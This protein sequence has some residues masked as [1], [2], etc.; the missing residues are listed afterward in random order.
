MSMEKQRIQPIE[1]FSLSDRIEQRITEYIK[2]NNLKPGDA[3][4]KEI[5]LAEWLG[6]SR[7]AVREAMMRLRTLGLIESKKHR[8]MVLKEPDLISNIERTLNY[9]MLDKRTLQDLFEFRLM[10]EMGMVDFVFLRKTNEQIRELEK[11][12]HSSS[13]SYVA[14]SFSWEEE[15]AF[16]SALYK[17]A[18]NQTLLRFQKLLLPVFQYVHDLQVHSENKLIPYHIVTHHDLVM[19]LKKGTPQTFREA[20][21]AHLNPHFEKMK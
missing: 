14:N 9:E 18:S 2:E 10:F 5:Q 11:L 12:A 7:T 19:E 1:P 6:V 4:P 20:M 16:H 3:L 21:R 17:M 8:G 13:Y 15:F